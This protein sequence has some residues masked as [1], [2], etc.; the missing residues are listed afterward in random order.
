MMDASNSANTPSETYAIVPTGD[1]ILVVGEEKTEL[2]VHSACMRTASRVF[3]AM[4][5]PRFLEGQPSNGDLPKK[6]RMP[7]DDATAMTTICNV[8]HHR[9]DLMPNVLEP[10]KSAE[11][12]L[13]ADKYDCVLL[14]LKQ[15]T[16]QWL[17]SKEHPRVLLVLK[18]AIS[19]WRDSK[20]PVTPLDLG[21]LLSAAYVCNDSDAFRRIT[22]K[23]ITCTSQPYYQV[24]EGGPIPRP[25]L[26]TIHCKCIPFL[27]SYYCC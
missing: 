21:S 14:V 1:I 25:I 22:Q 18:Q 17:D 2:R 10:E 12:L 23:L 8:I 3:D 5:G 13:V 15:A 26:Q 19:Q 7:D 9:N 20:E 4:F 6:I 24:I 27:A 11:I 16:F